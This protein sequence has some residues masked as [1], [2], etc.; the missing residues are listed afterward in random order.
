MRKSALLLMIACAAGVGLAR[1]EGGPARGAAGAHPVAQRIAA[2]D[3]NG[4]GMISR[5]EAANLPMLAKHFD[6]VDA[7]RDGFITRD[8]MRAAFMKRVVAHLRRVDSDGDARISR[9][10]AEA[11]APRLA[12]HFDKVDSDGDGFITREEMKAAMQKIHAARAPKS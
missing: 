8:E 12:A 2:A 4:D 7:N 6:A 9:A 1:A 3:T 10:E 11:G 5:E